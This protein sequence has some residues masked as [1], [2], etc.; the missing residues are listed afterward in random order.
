MGRLAGF[1]YRGIV[2]RRKLLLLL[3]ATRPDT[4]TSPP[5]PQLQ[6]ENSRPGHPNHLHHPLHC[7]PAPRMG[8]IPAPKGQATLG[9][10]PDHPR[11]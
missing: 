5:F 3:F 6:R 1:K 8:L 7:S 11:Y 4:T 10:R 2:K 9:H